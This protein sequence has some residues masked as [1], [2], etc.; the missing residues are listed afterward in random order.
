MIFCPIW[1]WHLTDDLEKL[2]GTSPMLL[3][4]LCIISWPSVISS[5]SFS[6]ETPNLAQN[7]RFFVP[8]DLDIWQMTLENNRAPHLTYFKLCASLHS[9]RSIQ[10]AVTL[11]KRQIQAR[12]I[13]CPMWPWNL[14]D[15]LEKQ[16]GTSSMLLQAVCMIS[17]PHVNSNWSYS[18][19]T[20]QL[21]VDLCDLDLLHGH[22]FCQW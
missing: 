6:P 11:R 5:W 20:A 21:G 14:T 15:D 3:Q 13:F 12:V 8:C 17:L 10:T 19:E 4:A 16:Y 7:R 9:H 18:P 2:E 22:H 1:P